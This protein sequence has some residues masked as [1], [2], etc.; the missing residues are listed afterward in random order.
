MATTATSLGPC[1]WE[2]KFSDRHP[3][4]APSLA[5]ASPNASSAS[6]PIPLATPHPPRALI[7]TSL[8]ISSTSDGAKV[9]EIVKEVEMS[10]LGKREAGIGR[11]YTAV[12]PAGPC[13]AVVGSREFTDLGR[14]RRFVAS[15]PAGIVVLSG[16]APGVD[17]CANDTARD[18]G[19]GWLE[20]FANWDRD[21]LY[22]AGRIRNQRVAERCDRMVAFWDGWS[23]GTQDAFTRALELGKH[24]VLYRLRSV[25][26]VGALASTP[27]AEPGTARTVLALDVPSTRSDNQP[28]TRTYRIAVDDTVAAAVAGV[29]IGKRLRVRAACRQV[30]CSDEAGVLRQLRDATYEARSIKRLPGKDRAA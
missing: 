25:A 5:A 27:A 29:R 7:S 20:Y 17:R 13:V 3:F 6:H 15:L 8:T 4:H 24:V 16:G 1:R 28:I 2:V 10:A 26:L 11:S 19:K 14:V 18:C 12:E 22:Y 21:G 23:T 9:N 30:L